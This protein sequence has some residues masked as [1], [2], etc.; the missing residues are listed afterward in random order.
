VLKDGSDE[1]GPLYHGWTYSA[2]P[3][4]AAAGVATLSLVDEMELV[5]NAAKM[6]PY[7]VGKLTEAL[8]SHPNVAEVRGEGL[9]AAVEFMDD[10]AN[11]KFFPT[12]SVAPR[13]SSAMLA[14][15]VIARAMPQ[16]DMIGFAPPLSVTRE[17]VDIVVEA[18]R[19]A[20]YEI[21]S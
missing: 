9:L 8:G 10:V 16:A 12:M 6:G 7:L 21:L 1:F 19:A 20:T 11:R 15:G 18:M 14:R 17:E 13:I 3:V 2:H 4:S 5:A